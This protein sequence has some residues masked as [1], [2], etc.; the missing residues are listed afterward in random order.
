M[1]N[2]F[3]NKV[4]D[5]KLKKKVMSPPRSAHET[6]LSEANA[7]AKFVGQNTDASLQVAS[8]PLEASKEVPLELVLE[9]FHCFH[10]VLQN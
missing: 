9:T 2:N 1:I 6:D 5:T 7:E 8:S 10:S 4:V 3:Y